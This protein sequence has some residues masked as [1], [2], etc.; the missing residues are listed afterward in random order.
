MCAR[1]RIV[2]APR[3]PETRRRAE[4]AR[5]PGLRGLLAA[6]I[7]A[8]GT[9]IAPA[10]P[11]AFRAPLASGQPGDSV[12]AVILSLNDEHGALLPERYSWS[13]DRPAGGAVAAAAYVSRVRSTSRC[14]VFL[15]SAGDLWQGTLISNLTRGRASI[16][17][18]N[19][20]G[21]DAVAIGNH[22]FD[23]GIR[24]LRELT[25]RARF[26][27]LSANI[28]GKG[29]DRHP[30]WA[31]PYV[32][33]EKEGVRVGVIGVTTLS[34]PYT[35]H[36]DSVADLDFRSIS[37]ALDRYIPRVRAAGAHFVVALI[38]AGGFCR[39]GEPP[40]IRCAGEAID[41]LEG[42]KSRFDY[43]ITGHTHSRISDTLRGAPVV[44]SYANLS[45]IGRGR[46]V[47]HPSGEVVSELIE[48]ATL[49]PDAAGDQAG[50]VAALVE[51]YAEEAREVAERPIATLADPLEEA[52]RGAS[53]LGRIIADAQRRAAGAEI[54]FMNNG[55]IRAAL[56][57][58]PVSYG[59]VFR[60]H[61]FQNTLIRLTLSGRLLLAALESSLDEEG[62]AS[63]I[64]GLKV[65][66]DAE[67]AE[68]RVL[69]ARLADGRP[70][71]P[72]ST[73]SVVVN[74]FMAAGGA[75]YWMFKEADAAEQ[76]GIVDVDALVDY[77][78]ALP[79]P[80]RAPREPRWIPVTDGR[81]TC[82]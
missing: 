26:P 1:L 13:G 70:V 56:P 40:G 59:E 24:T 3:S 32:I 49:Y 45:A 50:G 46:L 16:D 42:T 25:Q 14:P 79:Q 74:S 71:R 58:G 68:R 54:A 6:A 48:I 51:R 66:Y 75:G 10:Y 20:L 18:M 28:F 34:T 57:A 76:T 80:V 2:V 19:E 31:R 21:Y 55:G 47:R 78:Q 39:D 8:A 35:T 60:V 81:P 73:Y 44:Q 27:F 62:I 33:L 65:E 43:A 38:H 61:P 77:L 30:P 72:D 36:P 15:L 17:V 64:S 67:A 23:W 11:A 4:L 37:E 12:C 63:N 41:G 9:I 69:C 53:T 22:E 52:Y 29:T 82:S 5:A 7:V